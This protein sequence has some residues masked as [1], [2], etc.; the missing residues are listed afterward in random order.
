MC[1]L[2]LLVRSLPFES[3]AILKSPLLPQDV[4]PVWTNSFDRKVAPC[5]TASAT[6]MGILSRRCQAKKFPFVWDLRYCC[7]QTPKLTPCVSSARSFYA[8]RH[9]R[10][11]PSGN[12]FVPLE[13]SVQQDMSY[14]PPTSHSPQL[15]HYRSLSLPNVVQFL[16]TPVHSVSDGR[17]KKECANDLSRW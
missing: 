1:R 7:S 9:T 16:D 4:R 3:S 8:L 17:I 13:Q 10:E 6:D 15:P 14:L 5:T 2:W 12:P 11:C